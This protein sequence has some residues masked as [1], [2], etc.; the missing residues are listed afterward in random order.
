MAEDLNIKLNNFRED[1]YKIILKT[2]SEND[3]NFKKS[4]EYMHNKLRDFE[5]IIETFRFE[6][7]NLK[8]YKFSD[9]NTNLKSKELSKFKEATE[10]LIY[11]LNKKLT[12]LENE[13]TNSCDKYD[14]IFLNNFEVPGIIGN[15]QCIF[16]NFREFVEVKLII[17]FN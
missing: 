9:E 7:I 6:I 14:Q 4:K 16:K 8:D 17:I 10:E 2:D 13:F 3:E 15:T 1:I 12:N 5:K 11:Q